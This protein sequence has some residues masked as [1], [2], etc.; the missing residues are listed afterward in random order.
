MNRCRINRVF[1][2]GEK[3]DEG[4]TVENHFFGNNDE[5]EL[6][7]ENLAEGIARIDL[8]A[9]QQTKT[10]AWKRYMGYAVLAIK[11][12]IDKKRLE[13][14]LFGDKE[15]SKAFHNMHSMGKKA[16][17]NLKPK[18]AWSELFKTTVDDALEIVVDSIEEHMASS[19]ARTKNEYDKVCGEA[20]IPPSSDDL[21]LGDSTNG[22]DTGVE[23]LIVGLK[24][25]SPKRVYDVV[26]SV[27]DVIETVRLRQLER[28][29]KLLLLERELL[30]AA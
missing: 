21:R 4:T 14:T 30:R 23:D 13:K 29:I 1:P 3:N 22:G 27:I 24:S 18:V 2:P 10:V 9:R 6:F 28:K 20:V 15:P 11:S 5:E 26:E 25:C 17:A 7:I 8:D 16:L 19:G 12:G